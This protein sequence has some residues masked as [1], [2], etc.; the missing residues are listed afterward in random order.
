MKTTNIIEENT[1]R[2]FIVIDDDLINNSICKRIIQCELPETKIN[3]FTNPKK[4]LEYLES[5]CSNPDSN[6]ALL[7]LDINMPS[8]NGWELL[9]QLK[10]SSET[11][12][13]HLKIFML[14]SSICSEDKQKAGDNF[15]VSGYIEKPLSKEKMKTVLCY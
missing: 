8:L 7:F 2:D 5:T 1:E 4:G 15:L 6:N 3:T 11:V 13:K 14:S 12:K 9:E 10:K